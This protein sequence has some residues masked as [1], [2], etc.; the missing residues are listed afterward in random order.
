MPL[1][2]K[3]NLIKLRTHLTHHT[4]TIGISNSMCE[5]ELHRE[6][7]RILRSD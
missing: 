1:L 5:T 4:V 6:P 7:M 3:M 2:P